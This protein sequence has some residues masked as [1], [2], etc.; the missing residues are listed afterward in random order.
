MDM[1]FRLLCVYVA[2]S[3]FFGGLQD[4]RNEEY[5]KAGMDFSLVIGEFGL[6]FK[7]YSHESNIIKAI[8]IIAM[9]LSFIFLILWKLL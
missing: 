6:I 1:I 9:A 3:F 7:W 5:L 8:P 4:W 2:A